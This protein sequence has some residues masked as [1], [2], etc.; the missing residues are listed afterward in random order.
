LFFARAK[1][2]EL[3]EQVEQFLVLLEQPETR[4]KNAI[5]ANVHKQ[6]C[7]YTL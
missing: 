7:Y 6:I 4:E 3:L 1:F 2:P 5:K